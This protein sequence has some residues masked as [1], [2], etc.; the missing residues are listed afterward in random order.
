MESDTG[1]MVEDLR[2]LFT[3]AVLEKQPT[4]FSGAQ[5]LLGT[6]IGLRDERQRLGLEDRVKD[7]QMK[8]G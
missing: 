6:R 7:L 4:G 8:N 1:R 2:F 5:S 3:P